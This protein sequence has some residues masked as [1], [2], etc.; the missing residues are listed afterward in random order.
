MWAPRGQV[1]GWLLPRCWAEQWISSFAFLS[2]KMGRNRAFAGRIW[3][4]LHHPGLGRNNRV[5]CPSPPPGLRPRA[6]SAPSGP[7]PST[8][9][10]PPGPPD[11]GL[12]TFPP[13][14]LDI[15]CLLGSLPQLPSLL[16]VSASPSAAMEMFLY[17]QLTFASEKV[18]SPNH[19]LCFLGF[20]HFLVISQMNASP[21]RLGSYWEVLPVCSALLLWACTLCKSRA[22]SLSRVRLFMT[23]WTVARQA[24][25]HGISQARIL[26]WF[27]F[28]SPGDSSRPRDQT[29]VSCISC[30]AG[31][32]FTTEPPGKLSMITRNELIRKSSYRSTL[33]ILIRILVS[34]IRMK[35]LWTSYLTSLCLSFHYCKMGLM[36]V[37]CMVVVRVKW[38][39]PLYMHNHAHR[40]WVVWLR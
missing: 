16:W 12:C 26:E 17:L 22:K 30:T 9:P 10:P 34:L 5:E 23:P 15:C 31:R 29:C 18:K 38:E 24:P 33:I 13:L 20:Q 21:L 1:P 35:Q 6:H 28:P 2:L 14:C 19:L 32:F 37:P 4:S 3:A 8:S 27:P 11:P 36:R 25:A 7:W 39:H 40:H